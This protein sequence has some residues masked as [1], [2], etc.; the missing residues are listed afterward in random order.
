MPTTLR[1]PHHAAAL[2]LVAAATSMGCSEV[3]LGNLGNLGNLGAAV[4]PEV[5]GPGEVLSTP[6]SSDIRASAK[7]ATFVQ[8]AKDMT[9]VSEAIEAQVTEACRRIGTDIGIPPAQMQP[10]DGAGGAAKGACEPVAAAVDSI[11]RQG[12]QIQ[13]AVTPPSCQANVQ[14]EARCNG[15]CDVQ[16]DPGQIVAQCEP[17]RLSGFCQGRC[18]GQCEGRCTGTCH[19]QC[20]A[21]DA[22]GRCVGQ[23]NGS[24]DGG[25]DATC[26]AGCQGTWQA[27]RCEGTVRPPSVDA[28]CQASCKAHA[29]VYAT[30]T[31]ALVNVSGSANTDVALRL[32]RSLQ[33]NLPALLHAE[34]ALGRRLLNDAQVVVQVGAELPRVVGQAGAHALACAGAAAEAATSASLRIQI[35]V[36]ASA[37]ISGRVG[38]SGG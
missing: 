22:Q 7:V 32:G 6:F 5:A 30:C 18:T 1:W 8:A 19:G 38:A 27:P 35:S 9:A 10:Q 37:S 33:A 23:C 20:T 29:D 14:A 4:C 24:C 31:P 16:V 13:V 26:H 36:R 25:C 28:E 11:L 12:M 34:L 15:A 17:A 3:G 2:V 21:T